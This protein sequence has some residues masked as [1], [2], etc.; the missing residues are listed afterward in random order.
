MIAIVWA[1]QVAR[2]DPPIALLQATVTGLSKDGPTILDIDGKYE[3]VD[4][5]GSENTVGVYIA[6][7][8]FQFLQMTLGSDL[9]GFWEEGELSGP[10]H[11]NFKKLLGEPW[12][13]GQTLVHEAKHNFARTWNH[14][15]YGTAL[16]MPQHSSL[17]SNR[18]AFTELHGDKS[19]SARGRKRKGA[20]TDN[21]RNWESQ[22]QEKRW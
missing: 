15:Y 3:V 20:G 17:K 22:Y 6:P 8:P 19:Q 10:I 14:A 4:I 9:R 16:G 21:R 11:L 18:R 12:L 13:L 5:D 2:P 1:R 7:S